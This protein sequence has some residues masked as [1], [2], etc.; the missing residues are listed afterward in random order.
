M[1]AVRRIED[2]VGD[3]SA[4]FAANATGAYKGK[5]TIVLGITHLLVTN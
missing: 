3:S 5:D 2:V 4:S 1:I